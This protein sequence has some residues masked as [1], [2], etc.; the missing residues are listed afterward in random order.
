MSSTSRPPRQRLSCKRMWC[1]RE[2]SATAA[3]HTPSQES[4]TSAPSKQT[5]TTAR[6]ARHLIFLS[7]SP[8]RSDA[9]NKPQFD[10]SANTRTKGLWIQPPSWL[11][12]KLL[13]QAAKR[14]EPKTLP[15]VPLTQ[16]LSF[17]KLNNQKIKLHMKTFS[18][19]YSNTSLETPANQIYRLTN[20]YSKY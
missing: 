4:D 8:A 20:F 13:L 11:K 5:S 9:P 10:L 2:S 19:C 3:K 16:W 15:N 12:L 1:T 18:F 6:L 7:T 17:T 14:S